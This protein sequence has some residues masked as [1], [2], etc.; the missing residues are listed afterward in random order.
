MARGAALTWSVA[1]ASL[2]AATAR[3]DIAVSS[4][5]GHTV[6]TPA[7][8][9]SSPTPRP[10]TLSVIDLSADPPRVTATVEVPG[11]VVGP[12]TAVAVT[13]DE[14]FALV[15]SATKADAT[16][17]ALSPDDRVSVVDL[18]ADPPRIVQQVQAG[19]GAT[20]V[21][22]TPG[23]LALV[24]NRFEGTVSVLRFREGRLAPVGKVDLGNPKAGPSGIV[25]LPDGK[26]ALVS[27]DGDNMVSVLHIDGEAVT[28]DPRP[29]TTA[30]KP[31]TLQID[32]QGTLAAV[33][34]MG[35]GDGDVD[36]VSL[37]DLG[38]APF[39][40]VRT[41][42]VGE[43]PEGVQ[44]SPDGSL[45]AI[46]TQEGSTKA[47]D[48]PFRTEGGRLLLFR[49]DGTAL[50]PVA[51]APTGHW[52]QGVAFSRDGKTILVQQMGE[53]AIA[54]FRFD[55]SRLTPLTSLA[56]GVGPAAIATAW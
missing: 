42:S 47:P 17:P 11:S 13:P 45:L 39:R 32:R 26:A 1:F 36:S 31:Y 5:D 53:A 48:S 14:R 35:R 54:A 22:L 40:T 46:A 19:K 12:P 50:T 23:G 51:E 30:L 52:S 29:V 37:I 7:G 3:A 20:T 10:D 18:R 44:F 27:R 33:G 2:A 55:G 6:I 41:L 28:L 49:V 56:T 9:A 4:N 15:T 21:R 34:N 38:R 25:V 43:V 16:A 24:A 8:P